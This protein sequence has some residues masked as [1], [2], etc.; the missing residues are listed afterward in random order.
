LGTSLE[1]GRPRPF[2]FGLDAAALTDLRARIQAS[3]LGPIDAVDPWVYG[4]DPAYLEAV[5][6]TWLNDFDWGAWQATVNRYPQFHVEVGD[7]RLH[8]R[9]IRRRG[10]D[11]TPL[12]LLHGWPGSYLEFDKVIPLLLDA[13]FDLVI[14]SLPGMGFS[15]STRPMTKERIACIVKQLMTDVLGYERFGVHGGDIG[16]GVATR[17]GY[18]HGENLLG[19]HLTFLMSEP[20]DF[21]G[22]VTDGER[23]YLDEIDTWYRD[24][25]AY[26]EVQA[27]KPAT[28]G[29]A[30]NDSPAG[31]FA[32]IVDKY[33]AW[34]DCEGDVEKRF[35]RVELLTIVSLYWFTQTIASSMA[36]Y[37]DNRRRMPLPPGARVDTPTGVAVFPNEFKPE[38]RPPRALAER[39]FN[40]VRWRSYPSGGH[41][42]AL[43][44]PVVLAADIA[45]FFESLRWS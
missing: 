35:T 1:I 31:L 16:S 7:V 22:G 21:S 45:E 32:W 33:W 36:L 44:E 38:G 11:R 23:R 19:V 40:L 13:G 3:R 24:E 6:D 29:C 27:T 25:G 14:P 20:P 2:L 28:L 5:L 42:A 12:V 41:F 8:F 43:E 37:F 34:S 10:D 9:H 17:L 30:L 15:S 18:H 26:W 39:T 4:I